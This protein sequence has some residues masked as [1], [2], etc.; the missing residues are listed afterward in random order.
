MA[1]K[2]RAKRAEPNELA[3][4]YDSL[5][6]QYG[7]LTP[8]RQIHRDLDGAILLGLMQVELLKSVRFQLESMSCSP[9]PP[10]KKPPSGPG[11]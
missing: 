9:R 7:K 8:E 5:V 10:T 11:A 4:Q 2:R 6:Q 1:A 3:D